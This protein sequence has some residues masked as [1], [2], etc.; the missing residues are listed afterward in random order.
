VWDLD[1]DEATDAIIWLMSLLT[2]AIEGEL[3]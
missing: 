1:G 2:R 3:T